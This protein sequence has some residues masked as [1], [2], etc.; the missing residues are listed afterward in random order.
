M[1][2]TNNTKTVKDPMDTYK[3]A[4]IPDSDLILI[5]NPCPK[6]HRM[7]FMWIT[8]EEDDHSWLHHQGIFKVQ[9]ALPDMNPVEREFMITGYCPDCQKQ[10]FGNGETKRIFTSK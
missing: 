10:I 5:G 4:G 7:S 1:T 6:C 8:T 3:P 2:T 9:D